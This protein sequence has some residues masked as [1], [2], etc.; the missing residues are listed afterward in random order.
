MVCRER[1]IPIEPVRHHP[2][3]RAGRAAD[4]RNLD[5]LLLAH[6]Q[7][8]QSCHGRV[9][10]PSTA[11]KRTPLNFRVAHP[12]VFEGCGLDAASRQPLHRTRISRAGPTTQQLSGESHTACLEVLSVPM[13]VSPHAACESVRRIRDQNLCCD[14]CSIASLPDDSLPNDARDCATGGHRPQCRPVSIGRRDMAPHAGNSRRH[15]RD[16]LRDPRH[17]G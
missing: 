2:I 9:T 7:C 4:I 11:S 6:Q 10:Q 3:P 14:P 16:N 1:P 8:D 17:L 12:P 5:V 15:H 13:V